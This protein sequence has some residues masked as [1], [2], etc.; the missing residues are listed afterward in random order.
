MRQKRE[1][2]LS[3]AGRDDELPKTVREY[4]EKYKGIGVALDLVPEVLDL[5]HRDLLKLTEGGR[6]GRS[7]DFFSETI[8]RSLVVMTV[9]G[10]SYRETVIRIAD[11]EFLQDFV[12]TR[13]RS[14]TIPS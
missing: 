2:V 12:R 4:R 14:W 11:S 9:E 6:K 8:L 13:R 1:S 3:F 10:L 7:A 5:V